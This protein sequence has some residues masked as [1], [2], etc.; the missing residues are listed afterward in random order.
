MQ[1]V[2]I[3]RALVTNP[4]IILADEPT[5]AL[6][7]K[8]SEQIMELIK[9]IAEEKLVIMVTH[10]REIA[11]KYSTRIVELK[12]GTVI[13]DS[14]GKNIDEEKKSFRISKT[15]MSFLAAM[16]LSFNNIKTKKGRTFITSFAASIGII[17]IALILSLSNGFQKKIDEF[18][19]TTL[20]KA[21]ITVMSQSMNLDE[22]TIKGISD[23][24]LK[25]FPD[26]KEIYGREDVVES[27]IHENKITKEYEDYIK[28]MN[29]KYLGNI[30]YTKMVNIIAIN[31]DDNGNY[32]LIPNTTMT[33]M[34]SGSG[35]NATTSIWSMFPYRAGDRKDDIIS[36][37]FDTLAGKI[38]DNSP[39]L[40]LQVDSRNQIADS[41]LKQLG[42]TDNLDKVSFDDIM[43]KEIKIIL[44]NDY[45]T[46]IGDNFIPNTNYEELYN[47][48]GAITVKV[49]AIVRGVDNEDFSLIA[50]N[51]G[52]GYTKG[53]MDIVIEKNNESNIVKKQQELDYNIMTHSAFDNEGTNTKDNILG[54]LGA[55]TAPYMIMIYPKDFKAKDKIVKYLD[56]YNK[57]KE[58][59]EIVEYTDQAELITSLTKNIMDAITIVLIAFSSI[60]LIVSSIMIGIITYISVLER[61]KEIGILRALGARRKDI[62]RVFIAE[63]VIIGL[64][65]GLIG[66]GIA[67]ILNIPINIII[68]N[69]ANL[70]NVA[71]L[72][73]IHAIILISIS[74]IL[75]IID[76]RIPSG[77]ASR[78]NPVEALRT[79]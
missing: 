30:S 16:A 36:E 3:A 4:D 38:D 21:P 23:S 69:L 68:K 15:K 24:K 19:E 54:Y 33:N 76:G 41:I 18:Q 57:G 53:L 9:K 8:T 48:E 56:N 52:I 14:D 62:K 10:N 1:R 2:A 72:N 61:T 73:P 50:D 45:Y 5:G 7:S 35:I 40:I 60:S 49:Q 31:K 29:T 66:I 51:Y 28:N 6:D 42:F 63:V 17:G 71:Q 13:K 43:N 75:T 64:L 78:K 22:D 44:N 74:V 11:E 77:I 46:E 32:N 20:A 27:L 37:I 26:K 55:D 67:C 70:S 65:S 39:G 34:A 12:D 47:K 25:K 59:N 58:K 79:E